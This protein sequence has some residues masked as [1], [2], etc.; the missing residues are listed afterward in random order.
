M[1]E[2]SV[3]TGALDEAASG[4]QAQ[5]VKL[6]EDREALRRAA[7]DLALRWRGDGE[8][9]FERAWAAVDAALDEQTEAL[10]VIAS[11]ASTLAAT[12]GRAD[13]NLAALFGE[14]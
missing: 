5:A 11:L 4:L 8:E 9:A 10:E 3:R 6:A 14:R 2:I 7:G 12:Y 13:Q 1:D